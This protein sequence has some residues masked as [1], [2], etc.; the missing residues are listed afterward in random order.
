LQVVAT[1]A[2]QAGWLGVQRRV[3]HVAV[4]SSQY[5]LDVQKSTIESTRP[6]GLHCMTLLPT[7]RAGPGEQTRATQTP[8]LQDC[9]AASQTVP[10]GS[11]P[12]PIALHVVARFPSHAGCPGAQT[13]GRHTALPSASSQNSV[14]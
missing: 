3:R 5:S 14:D 11:N 10:P 4:T 2:S 7:Q 1:F 13:F 6:S 8:P 12:D 9:V